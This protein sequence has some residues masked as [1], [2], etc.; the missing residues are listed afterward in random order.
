MSNAKQ[1]II[2]HQNDVKNNITLVMNLLALR[3]EQHDNS[4]LKSPEIEIFEEFTPKLKS[5][6]YG[7]PNYNKCLKLMKP[8]LD[9]HYK[10]NKHHPEYHKN[11]IDDMTLID[12]IEMIADWIA[13]TKKYDDGNI[14]KSLEIN[15]ER[16]NISPQLL[17]ILENTVNLLK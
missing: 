2:N 8:A 10:T 7:S 5:M 4:K 6:S 3:A 16:F 11:G 15:K 1:E 12:L 13:A 14:K 9:H 17:S